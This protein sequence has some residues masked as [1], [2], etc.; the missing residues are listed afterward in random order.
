MQTIDYI[1]VEGGGDMSVFVWHI[2]LLNVSLQIIPAVERGGWKMLVGAD[3]YLIQCV[4]D[5]FYIWCMMV[6]AFIKQ[7]NSLVERDQMRRLQ[8]E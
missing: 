8:Y 1:E 6:A 3:M 4:Q 7:E 5:D 2:R